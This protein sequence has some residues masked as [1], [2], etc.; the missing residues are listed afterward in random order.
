MKEK[1]TKRQ[2]LIAL[3]AGFLALLMLLP[4]VFMILGNL[5]AAGAASVG[6]IQDQLNSLKSKNKDLAGKKSNLQT[7]LKS[8]QAD[9][10]KALQK[11]NLLEEQIGVLED[12]IENLDAQLEQY[13]FLITEKEG[14]VEAAKEKEA[15][16]FRLFC[17]QVRYM[18]EKGAISYWAILFS[19]SSFAELLDRVNMVNSIAD[20]NQMVCDQLLAAREA[21]EA[22]KAELIAAQEE[23]EATREAQAAAKTELET[24][25]GE[26]QSLI[27]E[28]A[29]DEAQTKQAIDELNKA[30]EAM[31]AEI[32]KKEKEL[33][34]AIAEAKRKN[35]NKY[36]F[37]PGTGYYWPLPKTN[38]TITSFFG[39]RKDPLNGKSANHTGT[40][41][42]ASTGTEIYAAHGGVVL[43]S[44]YHWSY[45]NYVVVS[46]GDGITTLYAHMSKRKVKAGDT[47][48]QGQVI[49][50]VGATGRVTGP[51]LHYEVRVNGTRVDALKYYPSIKW[52]NRTG[53]EYK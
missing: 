9:K 8:I 1:R 2:R 45:G 34:A 32:V 50:L 18:E 44:A 40:D 21:L 20:Y 52:I 16:Q 46:R 5:P 37:D 24:Q 10:S 7:Q 28:I 26:V 27:R 43:T 35:Q 48:A 12:E 25:K 31:D 22:A 33:E 51:H 41:I 17:D 13:A 11:K 4:M 14:E 39:P 42:G 36:Q 23:T 30:A 47:V 38:V 3:L 29:G 6:S 15:A 19:A 53:F 49:G